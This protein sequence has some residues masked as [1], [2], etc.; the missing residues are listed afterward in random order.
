MASNQCRTVVPSRYENGSS[1]N[2]IVPGLMHHL[3]DVE[4]WKNLVFPD[5][6]DSYEFYARYGRSQGFA[7][8][9]GVKNE[10]KDGNVVVSHKRADLRIE[11]QANMRKIMLLQKAMIDMHISCGMLQRA[12]YDTLLRTYGGHSNIDFTRQDMT[13]YVNV[14]KR[15]EMA[16]GNACVMQNWFREQTR[17]KDVFFYDIQV[18]Y[19]NDTTLIFWADTVMIADNSLFGDFISFD[20]TYM[21]NKQYRPLGIFVGFNHHMAT[22]VFGGALLYD[23]TTASLKWTRWSS[24]W[25]NLISQL[26]RVLHN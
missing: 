25:V 22:C 19:H 17:A 15:R 6:N 4:G 21:T 7:I 13:N 10:K 20:T 16:P 8:S 11:C 23:K 14:V 26:G 18:D 3:N 12:T 5:E 2:S 9:Q 1:S 24:A